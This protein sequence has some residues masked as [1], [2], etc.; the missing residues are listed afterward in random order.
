MNIVNK[1]YRF[2]NNELCHSLGYNTKFMEEVLLLD[3]TLQDVFA[4]FKTFGVF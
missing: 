1:Q 4:S 2:V 3:A